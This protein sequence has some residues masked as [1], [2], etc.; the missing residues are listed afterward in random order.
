MANAWRIWVEYFKERG[1]MAIGLQEPRVPGAVVM[2]N[3]DGFDLF[4]SGNEP[5]E[6]RV[7]GVGIA[8]KSGSWF[9]YKHHKASCEPS[10]HSSV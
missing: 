5:G 8:L 7:G 2:M 4:F 3:E 1:D 10:N 6:L 9:K